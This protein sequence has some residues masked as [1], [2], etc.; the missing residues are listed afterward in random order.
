ML[1]ASNLQDLDDAE[2][3]FIVG[4]RQ[5]KA[6]YDLATRLEMKGNYFSDGEVT[7]TIT[8]RHG[9]ANRERNPQIVAEPVWDPAIHTG[10]WR[11]IWQYRAKR[12]ARERTTLQSQWER[13]VDAVSG[14][15]P[16]RKPKFVTIHKGNMSVDEDTYQRAQATAGMK[17]YVTNLTATR[18]DAAEVIRSYHAL[19]HVEQSFRM[20]KHDLAARPVFHH[21]KDAIDTHLTVVI[22]SLAVARYL[23]QTTGMSIK[24]IV[25]ALRPLRQVAIRIGGHDITAQPQLTNQARTILTALGIPEPGH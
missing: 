15:R 20:S 10:S 7:E 25:R 5:T 16:A 13:A 19:W 3:G 4:S 23:T 8:P 21:T 6:P 18:M 24:T 9:Q 17:G 2:V 14:A 11:A 12:A 1:S 22:A